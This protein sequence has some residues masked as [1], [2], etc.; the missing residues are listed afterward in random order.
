MGRM[1]ETRNKYLLIQGK[2]GKE[3]QRRRNDIK[4]DTEGD[5]FWD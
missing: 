3:G 1:D 5:C 4:D 2:L